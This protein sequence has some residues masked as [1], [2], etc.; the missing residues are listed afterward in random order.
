MAPSRA[1]QGESATLTMTASIASR[2]GPRFGEWLPPSGGLAARFFAAHAAP[3]AVCAHPPAP[4]T[5][6][7]HAY[8]MRFSA[9]PLRP[10]LEQMLTCP[11][12]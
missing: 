8:I 11:R 7:P 10:V 5:K 4:P 2:G 12:G 3:V 6:L 9:F 1:S